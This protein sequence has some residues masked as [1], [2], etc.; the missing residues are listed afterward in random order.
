MS[1]AC[2]VGT[3]I[4]EFAGAD[5]CAD[6]AGAAEF[7]G[8]VS[9][10]PGT[11]YVVI[12]GWEP[13]DI[14]MYTFHIAALP[15]G[16]GNGV[17]DP[18]EFCDDGNVTSGEGCTDKCEV[19][20]DYTCTDASGDPAVVEPSVCTQDT[21]SAAV[22]PA[23]GDIVI[24]EFMPADNVSDTNCDGVTTNTAD[25]FVELVNV[26]AK[27][28]DLADVTLADSVVVRHVFA[29]GTTLAPGAAIVVWNG[30]APACAGV[31]NFAVASTGQLGL[32]DSGDSITVADAA[33]VT[34]ATTTYT[35]ATVNVS[36]NLSTE[37][38][39]STYVL[40]NAVGGAVG[41]FSPGKRANGSS[42]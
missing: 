36:F 12:D 30:G 22:P 38:S 42:F 31:T 3:E 10:G 24:N 34:I 33:A 4:S 15:P 32:N 25:E 23:P 8:W 39:G 1:T 40:H 19:E 21:T 5:G 11:Y 2:D 6:V 7:M 26:S 13:T 41:M 29:A 14:G 35:Q 9:M 17:A 20:P 27:T 16:C 18:L 37:M 28:L